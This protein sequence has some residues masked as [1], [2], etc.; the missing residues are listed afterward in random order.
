MKKN[1][2]LTREKALVMAVSLMK[3]RGMIIA[4]NG[5][6]WLKLGEPSKDTGTWEKI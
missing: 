6:R 3:R 5:V 4:P 1:K 2:K